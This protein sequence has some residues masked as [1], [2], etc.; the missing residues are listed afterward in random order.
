MHVN[1]YL[2]N[3][4]SHEEEEDLPTKRMPIREQKS[5]NIF[6]PTDKKGKSSNVFG[7]TINYPPTK[8]EQVRINKI[9]N[10]KSIYK[11]CYQ[12]QIITRQNLRSWK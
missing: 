12:S 5:T 4:S 9:N 7:V 2:E 8:D 10:V 1:I 6:D 3:A 11:Q